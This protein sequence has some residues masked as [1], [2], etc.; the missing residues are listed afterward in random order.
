MAMDK[1]RELLYILGA[2]Y[3][4]IVSTLESAEVDAYRG[5]RKNGQ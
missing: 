2:K 1:A 3:E 4:L 5:K